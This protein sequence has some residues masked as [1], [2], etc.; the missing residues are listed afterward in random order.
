MGDDDSKEEQQNLKAKIKL[1][2]EATNK[3]TSVIPN[4]YLQRT[5]NKIAGTSME[6]HLTYLEAT[7]DF[8]EKLRLYFYPRIF[9]NVYADTIDWN[10]FK[11]EFYRAT[12]DIKPFK[13]V[14]PL[15]LSTL[16]FILIS[17]PKIR[18][19]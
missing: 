19:L 1:R 4:M 6:E 18:N 9:E 11:P 12:L 7:G 13:T 2:L 10:Q 16:F 15:I 8:H 17:I 3:L 5:F 14:L